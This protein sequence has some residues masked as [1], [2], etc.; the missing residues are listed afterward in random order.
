MAVGVRRFV[1]WYQ[2]QGRPWRILLGV[3]LFAVSGA[4]LWFEVEDWLHFVGLPTF[5]PPA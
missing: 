1:G 5:G 2:R 3:L 4:I